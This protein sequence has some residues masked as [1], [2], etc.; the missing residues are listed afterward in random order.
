MLQRLEL[1]DRAGRTA[2][3]R[4]QI[5]DRHVRTRLRRR[6][7]FGRDGG[8]AGVEHALEQ[9]PSAIDLADHSVGID[10]DANSKRMRAPLCA[11]TMIVRSISTPLAFGRP[12]TASGRLFRR[13]LRRCARRRSVGRRH[14][15]G[16]RTACAGE[17]EAVARALWPASRSRSGGAWRLRRWRARARDRR[18]AMLASKRSR[19][20]EPARISAVAPSTAVDRERRRRQVAADLLHHDAGLDMAEAEPPCASAIRMP[21]KPISANCFQRPREKPSG[22]RSSRSLRR[23]ATGALVGQEARAL[24]RSMRLFFVEDERHVRSCGL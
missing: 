12:R 7:Q 21:E 15:R 11:S 4:L 16:R 8:A 23:C 13:A 22:L 24:S 10:R 1:A 19:C 17:R 9:A 14:G 3:A 20:A 18:R 6:R 2:C 5:G